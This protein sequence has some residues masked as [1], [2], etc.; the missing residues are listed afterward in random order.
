MPSDPLGSRGEA[1]RLLGL[2]DPVE[3]TDIVRAYRRM[4]RQ[5]HPDLGGDPA[6]FRALTTARDVLLHETGAHHAERGGAGN[7][8]SVRARQRTRRRLLRR[9][10]QRLHRKGRERGNLH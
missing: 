5:H 1:L 4:A 8:R 9:L 6:V 3:R 2:R 10:R 7:G